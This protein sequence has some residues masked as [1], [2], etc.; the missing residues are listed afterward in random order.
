M[1]LYIYID[2]F[3]DFHY[4]SIC[5]WYSFELP[6]FVEAIQMNTHKICFCTEVDISTQAVI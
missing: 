6:Q 2:I 5:F 3:S 1:M 4:K